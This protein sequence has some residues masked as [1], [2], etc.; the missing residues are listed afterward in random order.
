ME[1][2]FRDF[3][4]FGNFNEGNEML[5]RSVD[6]AFGQQSGYIQGAFIFFNM[7]ESIQKNFVF[8][9]TSVSDGQSYAGIMLI[10]H[11]SGSDSQV[12]DFAVPFFIPG[13]TDGNSRS[14]QGAD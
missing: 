5:K 7:G 1:V 13:K 12:A 3:V 4:F 10:K 8:G 11:F 9:K 2:Y 14:L 6:V